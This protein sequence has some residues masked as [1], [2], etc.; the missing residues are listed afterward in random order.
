MCPSRVSAA[1]PSSSRFSCGLCRT[2]VHGEGITCACF[3]TFTGL[4]SHLRSHRV[5]AIATL[6]VKGGKEAVLATQNIPASSCV[7]ES[8]PRIRRN[9]EAPTRKVLPISRTKRPAQDSVDDVLSSALLA[10]DSDL[11]QILREVQ[12]VFVTLRSQSPDPESLRITSHPAVWSAVR[13]TL[14]DRELRYLALTDDL[15]CLYNRR[16]F[17]A[18]ATQQIKLARRKGQRLLFFFCDVDNLKLI[19][20]CYGHRAGDMALIQVADALEHTF[21]G[22]DIVARLSGDEFAILALEAAGHDE[23][24]ILRRFEKNLKRANA[25]DQR[26]VLSVSVGCARFDPEHPA[27]LGDL[28]AQADRSMYERKRLRKEVARRGAKEGSPAQ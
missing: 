5:N 16:A 2:T 1:P 17:L 28:M 18:A 25:E 9:Q 24:T 6:F 12:R 19:N 22:S 20:D 4:C 10:T 27:P 15:T 3:A 21:R 13:Q 8:Q 14:M 26:Y 23:A 11:Q 7:S